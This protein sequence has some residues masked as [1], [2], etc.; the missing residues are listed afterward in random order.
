VSAFG[1][2]AVNLEIGV[3][4]TFIPRSEADPVSVRELLTR[5]W[6]RDWNAEIAE[7][8]IAWRYGARADGETLVAC[9]QRRCVGIIDSFLRPYWIAGQ[10]AIVRETCDWFCL[11]EYRT[12][13]VGLHLMR[14]MMA[15][16]EPILVIGGTDFT[17]DLLPRLKWA[18]L[19]SV[20]S[21][22]LAISARTA[23]G[24][25][26]H[27]RLWR[28]GAKFARFIPDVPLL[29]RLHRL[30]PPSTKAKVR[31]LSPGEK[32]EVSR[33]APYVFAPRLQTSI[34]DWL[35]SAPEELGKVVQLSFFCDGE[36][37]GVSISRLQ[38]LP[39]GCKATIVHLHPA[40]FELIGW[41]VSETAHH[42]IEQGAGAILCRTSC[43]TTGR[44]LSALGFHQR[45][46]IPAT[47]WPANKLLPP[48]P[49][50]L[51]SLQADDGLQFE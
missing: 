51:T 8:Y 26:A 16:P 6:D 42:L 11:P 34:L 46:S 22:A 10:W 44:A 31:I 37:A 15:K 40:R 25:I 21:F 5:V 7:N 24:L 18:R 35:A 2:A 19:R 47:W 12:F 3:S 1:K 36:P 45:P 49:F 50:L 39:F 30:P 29:R 23:A 43:P 33:L 14:R 32:A 9:D 41:I 17:L 28:R 20:D 38:M 13:G 4:I 48:G 27:H